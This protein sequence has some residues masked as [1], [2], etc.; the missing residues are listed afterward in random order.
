MTEELVV[1]QLGLNA[2]NMHSFTGSQPASTRPPMD[3][4]LSTASSDR[5]Q[6]AVPLQSNGH[7]GSQQYESSDDYTPP[8]NAVDLERQA[9]SFPTPPESLPSHGR[10]PDLSPPPHP[11][12]VI[13]ITTPTPMVQP[14][15]RPRPSKL[16]EPPILAPPI[17]SESGQPPQKGISSADLFGEDRSRKASLTSRLGL[18]RTFSKN[19]DV[20]SPRSVSSP[21]RSPTSPKQQ[22]G[23]EPGPPSPSSG[24]FKASSLVKAF[25]RRKSSGSGSASQPPSPFSHDFTP[26]PLP[27]KDYPT[28]PRAQ[29]SQSESLLAPDLGSLHPIPSSESIS[30]P[31]SSRHSPQPPYMSP[32]PSAKE[33]LTAAREKRLTEETEIQERFRLQQLE[34]EQR[35]RVHSMG[36]GR[37]AVVVDGMESDDGSVRLAYDESEPEEEVVAA[38]GEMERPTAQVLSEATTFNTSAIQP[39]PEEPPFSAAGLAAAAK[40]HAEHQAALREAHSLH[41]QGPSAVPEGESPMHESVTSAPLNGHEAY[42]DHIGAAA[43][44]RATQ[45]EEAPVAEEAAPDESAAEQERLRLAQSEIEASARREAEERAQAEEKARIQAELDAEAEVKAKAIAEAEA[46]AK[47]A[48]EAEAKVNAAAEA[49]AARKAALQEQ[50]VRAKADGGIMLSG[51]GFSPGK[52]IGARLTPSVAYSANVVKHIVAP[53][54]VPALRSRIE[55]VQVGGGQLFRH[56]LC[57]ETDWQDAKAMTTIPLHGAKVSQVYEESQVQDS[58]KISSGGE[59]VSAALGRRRKNANLRQF[60]L[61]ADSHEDKDTVLAAL[62]IATA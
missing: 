37:E 61:F 55:A 47:A 54:M 34:I 62:H 16:S 4:V 26:P 48:A 13:D 40:A 25:H 10:S 44:D 1:Q 18:D 17:G 22:D 42:T 53:Q 28:P 21:V 43:L 59:D 49:E 50:L 12:E 41:A 29:G 15:P 3:R 33:I 20:S 9:S 58:F 6:P 35:H 60:F 8:D 23:F 14:P 51:V 2:P 52:I 57:I 19:K 32:S 24:R 11:R 45:A 38:S 7:H 30:A 46:Q 56:A 27:P 36:S 39:E 31:S 5:P